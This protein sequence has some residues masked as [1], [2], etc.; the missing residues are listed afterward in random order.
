MMLVL[1]LNAEP[2]SS[3]DGNGLYRTNLEFVSWGRRLEVL[4]ATAAYHGEQRRSLQCRDVQYLNKKIRGN[5]SKI[6][7]WINRDIYGY[8]VLN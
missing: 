7:R 1:K 6:F 5:H 2:A 3:P 4:L 8:R